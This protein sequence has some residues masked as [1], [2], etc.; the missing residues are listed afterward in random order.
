[1]I[2]LSPAMIECLALA[3]VSGSLVAAGGGY[4]VS[5]ASSA[6][7][8]ADLVHGRNRGNWPK[9]TSTRSV[10]ACEAR[11]WLEPE[12]TALARHKNPRRITPSGRAIVESHRAVLDNV[13]R[14]VPA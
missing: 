14:R 3:S 7:Q 6:D 13:A 4:W 11:G 12:H 9:Y 1:M 2:D 8:R 5:G 10:Y